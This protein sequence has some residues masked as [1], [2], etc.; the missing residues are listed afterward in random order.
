MQTIPWKNAQRHIPPLCVEETKMRTIL[1]TTSINS[2]SLAKA[3]PWGGY[4]FGRKFSASDTW[5]HGLN[6]LVRVATR[7][8]LKINWGGG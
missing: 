7:L 5:Y 3:D 4:I 1:S 2:T 6:F 8:G